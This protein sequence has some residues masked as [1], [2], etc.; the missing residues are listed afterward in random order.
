M[1]LYMRFPSSPQDLGVF[2]IESVVDTEELF[3]PHGFTSKHSIDTSVEPGMPYL[4]F[5][6]E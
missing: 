3:A 1:G 6:H 5:N 4:I 2:L